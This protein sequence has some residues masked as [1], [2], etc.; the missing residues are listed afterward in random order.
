MGNDP[1]FWKME[2]GLGNGIWKWKWDWK[3][4][5][6]HLEIENGEWDV[7]M[8]MDIRELEYGNGNDDRNEE[9]EMR[10]LALSEDPVK[11]TKTINQLKALNN[12]SK[13]QTERAVKKVEQRN[14]IKGGKNDQQI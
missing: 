2:M 6:E 13:N 12:W 1:G 11:S 3:R 4:G 7:Q 10:K 8:E 9:I 5:C 14:N